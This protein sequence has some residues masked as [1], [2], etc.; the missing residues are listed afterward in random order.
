MKSMNPLVLQQLLDTMPKS[1]IPE[2]QEEIQE[3]HSKIKTDGIPK[4][5]NFFVFYTSY[6]SQLS[7]KITNKLSR[8]YRDLFEKTNSVSISNVFPHNP[9]EHPKSAI[10]REIERVERGFK[11]VHAKKAYLQELVNGFKKV[12]VPIIESNLKGDV[13]ETIKCIDNIPYDLKYDCINGYSRGP[14][15]VGLIAL[16]FPKFD[17]AKGISSILDEMYMYEEKEILLDF[18]LIVRKVRNITHKIRSL[19]MQKWKKNNLQ[20]GKYKHWRIA[21]HNTVGSITSGTNS[22]DID[23]ILEKIKLRYPEI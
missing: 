8:G 20:N 5:G 2:I 11:A 13:K 7:R 1:R 9:Y 12:L 3:I 17:F 14:Y 22:I 15:L 4:D 6:I 21:M 19:A 16:G 23:K 18:I 10:E